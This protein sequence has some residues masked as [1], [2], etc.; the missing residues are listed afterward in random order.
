MALDV[1]RDVGLADLAEVADAARAHLTQE[2]AN[3]RQ[4]ADD[5]LRRQ[6]SF[7][8]QIVAERLEDLLMWCERWQHRRRDRARRA[9]HR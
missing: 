5:G 7:L 1:A 8:P 3:E 9:K 6:T 2:Q 4:M